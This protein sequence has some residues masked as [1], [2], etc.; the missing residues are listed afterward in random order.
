MKDPAET[1][2]NYDM[3]NIYRQDLEKAK[4][5]LPAMEKHL[6][7]DSDMVHQHKQKI[8]DL[9]KLIRNSSTR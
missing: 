3:T 4:S 7:K 6:G 9:Q 5:F 8:A 1:Q 2:M